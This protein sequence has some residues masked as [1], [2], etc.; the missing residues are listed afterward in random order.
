MR[1]PSSGSR[2]AMTVLPPRLAPA[3]R[4]RRG[5]YLR[6]LIGPPTT[7]V[8]SPA[9]ID[10]RRADRSSLLCFT[11]KPTSFWLTNGGSSGAQ[12]SRPPRPSHCV[13]IDTVGGTPNAA[14]TP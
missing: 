5:G 9:S 10:S 11:P 1:R 14:V 6:Q 13:R 8:T 3:L 7:G 4:S 2:T 12:M